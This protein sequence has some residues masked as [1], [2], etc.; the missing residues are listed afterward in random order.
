M[1]STVK[2]RPNHYEVLGL[3]P[4]ASTDEI[5]RAFAMEISIF[6]PHGFG[7]LAD[8]TVA[9]ETLRNPARRRAYDAALGLNAKREPEPEHLLSSSGVGGASFLGRTGPFAEPVEPPAKSETTPFIA[10]ALRELA[11]PE[12]LR[13]AVEAATPRPEPPF[14]ALSTSEDPDLGEEGST[15]W[16]RI[17]IAAGG[18]ALAVGLLGAWAGWMTGNGAVPQPHRAAK[19]TLPPPTTFAVGDPAQAGAPLPVEQPRAVRPKRPTLAAAPPERHRPTSRLASLDEQLAEPVAAPADAPAAE[20]A[21]VTTVAASL[22][23]SNGVIARTIA[24]IGYPCGEV[25]STSAGASPGVFTVNCTSGHSYQA[26]PVRGRY[27]FRRLAN[28]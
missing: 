26:A 23:L 20:A 8:V 27:H 16:K 18:V 28:R 7:G 19:V 22:P 3:T 12:P 6:R 13:K 1:A 2:S 17:G 5:A 4:T 21:P 10:A 11:S 14:E 15:P 9:Y 25:A 24:R